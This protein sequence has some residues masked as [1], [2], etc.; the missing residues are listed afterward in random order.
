VEFVSCIVPSIFD[1]DRWTRIL[2][3]DPDMEAVLQSKPEAPRKR[4]WY[5]ARMATFGAKTL[6]EFLRMQPSYTVQ[7]RVQRIRCPTLVT[8]GEGDF[9]SQI[10]RL[11]NLLTCEK[12][13][14][15][16]RGIGGRRRTLLRPRSDP[17]GERRV[18]LD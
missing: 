1:Q 13:F 5:G 6:G 8:E 18:R 4:E 17:L 11:Y 10:Q 14:H 7:D 3:A 9:A 15:R 12:R 2:A 16:F